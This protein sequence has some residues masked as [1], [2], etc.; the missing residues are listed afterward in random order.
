MIDPITAEGLNCGYLSAIAI[1]SIAIQGDMQLI[2][3]PYVTN[4]DNTVLYGTTV[5]LV[6]E[7]GEIADQYAI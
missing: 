5:V 4:A 3:T 2:V 6:I 7:D 1:D